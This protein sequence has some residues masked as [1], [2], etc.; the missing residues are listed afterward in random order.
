MLA[1]HMHGESITCLCYHL[2][3]HL[4]E[5][6]IL[7][8][9]LCH[10]LWSPE[11]NHKLQQL[12]MKLLIR[13]LVIWSHVK[14]G[15]TFG[16]MKVWQYLFS[17][18]LHKKCMEKMKQIIKRWLNHLICR[19]HLIICHLLQKVY[20]NS[21]WIHLIFKDQLLTM[22]NPLFNMKRVFNCYFNLKQ[23]LGKKNSETF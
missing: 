18:R 13:G 15:R 11:T 19:Q 10:P 1:F 23:L 6:K 12:F 14:V 7:F 17:V 21:I 9:P 5:W 2:L 20:Q 4:V 3:S 22:L 8:S 16:L